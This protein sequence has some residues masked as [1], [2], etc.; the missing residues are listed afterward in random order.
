MS[1]PRQ[2]CLT[3]CPENT[4]GSR[5]QTSGGF[6]K[7][8]ARRGRISCGA[9]ILSADTGVEIGKMAYGTGD[10]PFVRTSDLA[11]WEIKRDPKQEFRRLCM[12]P[13]LRKPVFLPVMFLS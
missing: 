2:L 1:V 6:L 7:S 8:G 10:I 4:C 11:Q 12:M 3:L 9:A 5:R 13:I